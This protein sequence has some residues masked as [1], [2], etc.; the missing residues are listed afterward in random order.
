MVEGEA[1]REQAVL[2]EKNTWGMSIRA[3][4]REGYT[5]HVVT[6]PPPENPPETYFTAIVH[7]DGES[8]EYGVPALPP[9]I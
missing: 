8:R 7:K 9:A 6:M 4:R 2:R 1:K 5:V 3:H